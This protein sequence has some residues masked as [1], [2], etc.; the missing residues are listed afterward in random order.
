M[1]Q[2]HEIFRVLNQVQ[3]LTYVYVKYHLMKLIRHTRLLYKY[4]YWINLQIFIIYSG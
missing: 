4:S 1:N 2:E 3:Q